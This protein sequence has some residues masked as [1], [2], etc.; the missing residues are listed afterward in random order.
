MKIE[1]INILNNF[2]NGS[3]KFCKISDKSNNYEFYVS[4]IETLKKLEIMPLNYK[5]I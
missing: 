2:I 3:Y 5:D 4:S 1:K